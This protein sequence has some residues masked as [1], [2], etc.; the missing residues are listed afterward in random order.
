METT[1][2]VMLVEITHLRNWVH[3]TDADSI[4]SNSLITCS[5][6]IT[7]QFAIL[8]SLLVA[9]KSTFSMHICDSVTLPVFE[10]DFL[11]RF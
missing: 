9:S 1:S 2:M 3:M 5:K 4:V 8:S 11:G 6:W 7:W 10:E